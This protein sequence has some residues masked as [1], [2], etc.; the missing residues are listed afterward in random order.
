MTQRELAGS[1]HE[2]GEDAKPQVSPSEELSVAKHGAEQIENA[3]DKERSVPLRD[4]V[5]RNPRIIWWSFFWCMC[6]VG[7]K[8][9]SSTELVPFFFSRVAHHVCLAGGFDTQVNGAIIGV[10]AFRKFY[11]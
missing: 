1:I 8:S 6:A 10:P 3:I 4:I 9:P 11:G 5:R 7:C 2:V